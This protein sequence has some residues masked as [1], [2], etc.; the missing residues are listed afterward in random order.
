MEGWGLGSGGSGEAR[1]EAQTKQSGSLALSGR[2][3]FTLRPMEPVK[4]M[5]GR[6]SHFLN[7]AKS[8]VT[9]NLYSAFT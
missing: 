6:A 3:D 4:G 8:D 7:F 9:Q 2:Q 1:R 5:K